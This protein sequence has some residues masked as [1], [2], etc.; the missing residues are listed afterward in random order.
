MAAGLVG[1][2]SRLTLG[3]KKYA[4][5]Q[6]RMKEIAAEA[7]KLRESLQ[8]AVTLD[9]QSFDRVLEALKMPKDTETEQ[10]ARGE[11]IERATHGAAAVPLQVAQWSARVMQ[12]VAEVAEKG[13]VNALTDAASA[14]AMARAALQASGL[15]VK[16][17]AQSVNDKDAAAHWLHTL[18]E[19]DA[20]AQ[21]AEARVQ[22]SLHDRGNL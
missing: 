11:A 12:L 15:N 2:V 9:A 18:A 19:A 3:K 16:T 20:Q 21:T 17:N 22:A 10:K 1:M 13:N 4:A 6:E 7:D 5:V 14:A 8:K